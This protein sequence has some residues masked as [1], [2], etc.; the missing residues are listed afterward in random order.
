[1][2]IVRLAWT[3]AVLLVIAA[4]MFYVSDPTTTAWYLYI[5]AALPLVALVWLRVLAIQKGR[6]DKPVVGPGGGMSGG[7]PFGPP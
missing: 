6:G 5:V 2:V 3:F 4:G 1:M 7:T